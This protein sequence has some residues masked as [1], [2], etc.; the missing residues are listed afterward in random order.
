MKRVVDKLRKEE[1]FSE[2]DE[3]TLSTRHLRQMNS[4]LPVKLRRQWV[5]PFTVNRV[6]SPM[7]YRLDLP[8]GWKIH[9]TFHVS[10]LKRYLRS[11]EFVREVE[12]PPPELVEGTLEYEVEGILWHKGKSAR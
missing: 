6:M 12:P 11:E 9:P 4:H 3:V 10:Q 5:G 7:A 8:Q 2:G 1:T